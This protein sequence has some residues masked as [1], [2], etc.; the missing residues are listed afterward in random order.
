MFR[1]KQQAS[2]DGHVSHHAVRVCQEHFTPLSCE[3]KPF[4][5]GLAIQ[6]HPAGQWLSPPDGECH[7]QGMLGRVLSR[8]L[9]RHQPASLDGHISHHSVPVW[10]QAPPEGSCPEAGV[11]RMGH[12]TH[13]S[14]CLGADT[15]QRGT[16]TRQRTCG[17]LCATL[18]Q[19]LVNVLRRLQASSTSCRR[20]GPAAD[21]RHW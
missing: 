5:P 8:P 14:Q 7:G 2:L 16:C 11:L 9:R 20:E 15:E 12:L 6:Q 17:G 13:L 1:F 21:Q 19:R 4:L 10:L 3:R 18:R